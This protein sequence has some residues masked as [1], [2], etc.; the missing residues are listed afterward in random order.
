MQHH[1]H[2]EVLIDAPPATVW[3]TLTDLAK[4]QDWNP[5]IVSAEGQVAVG[6]R[7]VNRIN[8]PGGKAVTFRPTVTVVEQEKTFEW[9]GRLLVPGLFDGR[10]RFDLQQTESGGTLL[11]HAETFRGLLVRFFRKSLDTNTRQGFEAMNDALKG[12]A[13]RSQQTSS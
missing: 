8:P 12:R 13:E 11:I 5:F 2:T 7:L 4:Y 6:E 1:I 9:L 10:H 3:E